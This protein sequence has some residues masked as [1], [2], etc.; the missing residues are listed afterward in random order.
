VPLELAY[1]LSEISVGSLS[2]VVRVECDIPGVVQGELAGDDSGTITTS[3]KI[4]NFLLWSVVRNLPENDGA[5]GMVGPHLQPLHV[6]LHVR[7]F[8]EYL[9]YQ[10]DIIRQLLYLVE[11]CNYANGHKLVRVHL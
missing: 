10:L 4:L 1:F 11:I 7:R 3:K 2:V 5:S 6:H 9:S 8:S